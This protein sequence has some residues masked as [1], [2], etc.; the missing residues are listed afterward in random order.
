MRFRIMGLIRI[1]DKQFKP[2]ITHDEIEKRIVDV[3]SKI[4]DDYEGQTPIFLPVLNGAFMFSADLMK[5]VELDCEIQF[6]KCAS[7]KG[8]ESTGKVKQLIG[9]PTDIE[10]Q[11]IVII[12]DIVDT[13]RTIDVLVNELKKH[14]PASIAICSLL[15]KP[16]SYKLEHMIDYALF[17]IP[18]DFIIGYGLDYDGAGRNLKDIY[19]IVAD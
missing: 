6:V 13:G 4:N 7:Y 2:F 17:E 11:S 5:H 9:A 8:T 14:N 18:N 10:G 12:E 15:L 16:D 3:A 1:K 19:K